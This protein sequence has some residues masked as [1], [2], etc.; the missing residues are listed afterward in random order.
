MMEFQ[1]ILF[2]QPSFTITGVKGGGAL[3]EGHMTSGLS[4][5]DTHKHKL[6][7]KQTARRAT[8]G[9]VSSCKALS[10]TNDAKFTLNFPFNSSVSC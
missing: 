9:Q 5:V 2:W 8:I 6:Q 7:I 3:P 1:L 10:W 4:D